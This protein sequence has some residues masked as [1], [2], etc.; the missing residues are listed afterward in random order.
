MARQ[1]GVQ[2]VD[3]LVVLRLVRRLEPISYT[4]LVGRLT[5]RFECSD[6]TAK[7]S[8]SV[9]RRG[10]WLDDDGEVLLRAGD[11]NNAA[12]AGQQLLRVSA[13]GH[14]LLNHP[15]AA[16]VLRFA[17]RLFTTCPS[18]KV[19]RFQEAADRAEGRY[20]RLAAVERWLLAAPGR[21]TIS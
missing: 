4:A 15:R 9:L 19:R 8:I 13:R 11:G 2:K 1:Y 12:A 10:G 3:L 17:R 5:K 20:A 14:Y 6:R 18:P 7:D 16:Q 21:K